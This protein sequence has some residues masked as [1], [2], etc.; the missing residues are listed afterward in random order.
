MA[1]ELFNGRAP[2][3]DQKV[4]VYSFGLVL[5]EIVMGNGCLSSPD[6]VASAYALLKKGRRPEIPA[7]VASPVCALITRCWSEDPTSRP[8]F[9]EVLTMLEG[10]NYEIVTGVRSS[11][12]RGFLSVI[13]EEAS[14]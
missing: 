1:P 8:S 7:S 13:E 2:Q 3:Y 12:V 9:A 5:Y 11:E 10:M 4:D 14:K 6:G